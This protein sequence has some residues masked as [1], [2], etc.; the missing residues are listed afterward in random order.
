MVILPLVPSVAHSDFTTTI[1]G[2]TYR[3]EQRWNARDNDGAG[4]W[5]L[6]AFAIDETPVFRGVKI[7]L[8]T[9]LARHANHPLTR[10]GVLIAFDRSDA[11][12][13]AAFDDLGTRVI[14][15][16]MTQIELVAAMR[17]LQAAGD[18]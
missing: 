2:E 17:A 4:A 13:D 16:W 14:V 9:F 3:F 1:A 12:A 7:V 8:G 11:R 6:D 10:D 5:Y 18:L 15:V